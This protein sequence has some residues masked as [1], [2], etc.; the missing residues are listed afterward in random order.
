MAVEEPVVPRKKRHILR[1]LFFTLIGV[2]AILAIVVA[3]QPADYLVQRSATINAPAPVVFAQVNDFHNWEAWSPWAKLDPTAK[4]SFEGPP[5]GA[6]AI[7]RWSGNDKVGEGLMTILE[8][9]PGERVKIKLEFIRP[10]ADT[11]NTDFTFKPQADGTAVTWSMSGHRNFMAK[12]V[13][14]FMNMDKMVGGDS[15]KGLA[16]MKTAAEAAARK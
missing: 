15:E 8:S 16:Q 7:F 9:Q 2:I 12:A 3:V 11:A 1:K 4:N 5:A 10:F 14:L 13:C 6:G